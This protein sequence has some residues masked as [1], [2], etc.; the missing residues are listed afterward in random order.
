M[1]EKWRKCVYKA[2]ISEAILADLSKAVD[3]I[4]HDLSIAKLAAYGSNSLS[5][6]WRVF[7][8]IDRKEQKLMMAL[9]VTLKLYIEFHK[10]QFWVPYF[11][12]SI[13]VT[14]FLT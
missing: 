11:S 10:G 2:G 9:F 13:S 6:S 14:Y 1:S 4:L 8:L 3:C 5:E 12:I 7:F